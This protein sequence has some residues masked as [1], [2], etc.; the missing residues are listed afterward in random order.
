[1]D[2]AVNIISL[3]ATSCRCHTKAHAVGKEGRLILLGI[4]AG[5]EGLTVDQTQSELR[6][7]NRLPKESE[8]VLVACPVCEFRF[9]T[10][11]AY[12]RVPA[13]FPKNG[14]PKWCEGAGKKP[15]KVHE[16]KNGQGGQDLPL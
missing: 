6:R 9:E 4:I 2:V 3:G 8:P 16:H 1:L 13:H 12:P 11:E 14:G 5:R 10:H 7:L 15:R